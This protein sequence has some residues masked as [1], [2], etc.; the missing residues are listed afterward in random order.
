MT[1]SA[2][3]A[4]EVGPFAA[5]IPRFS[6]GGPLH[7]PTELPSPLP[8][9]PAE[10]DPRVR[11][12]LLVQDRAVN[13]LAGVVDA[14]AQ[15]VT[16]PP[17]ARDSFVMLVSGGIVITGKDGTETSFQAGDS[18]VL[19][20][21]AWSRW[22]QPGPARYLFVAAD[23]TGVAAADPTTVVRIDPGVEL[24]PSAPPPTELLLSEV[25]QTMGRAAFSTTDQRF[26]AGIWSATPYHRKTILFPRYEFMHLLE[27]EVS[28]TA[29]SGDTL[30]FVAGDSFMVPAGVE[31]DWKNDRFVRKIYCVFRF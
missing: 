1:G 30:R 31:C 28:F 17:A 18:F 11:A 13:L 29:P 12:S 9:R 16:L 26:A 19:P 4:P 10:P 25:P 8:G 14:P 7:N 23:S 27:G 24:A 6:H 22:S 15:T 3:F 20:A 21:G 5:A 2:K